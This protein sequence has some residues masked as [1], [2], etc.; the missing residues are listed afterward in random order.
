NVA[1]V[2]GSA[3]QE[4]N[5]GRVGLWPAIFDC[6]EERRHIWKIGT[7]SKEAIYFDIGIHAVFEFAIEFKEEFV[8]KEHRRVA[9]L[10]GQHVRFIRDGGML[11]FESLASDAHKIARP[12]LHDLTLRDYLEQL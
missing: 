4:T 7:F 1:F 6:P 9:L 2:C 3:L 10:T 11:R 12:R 8:I 5:N